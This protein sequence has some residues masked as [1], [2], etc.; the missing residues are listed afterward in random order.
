M[1]E[2]FAL[3]A[4]CLLLAAFCFSAQNSNQSAPRPPE[5][6]QASPSPTSTPTPTP[7]PTPP[8]TLHQWGAVTLFHG[9]PSNRVRAI[10]QGA[11]GAMWFGTDAGLAKY[12][13]R[14]TQAV[15]AEGLSGKRVLALRL[16]E[17]GVLWVGTEDGAARVSGGGEV[18]FIKET[19]GKAVTSVI[20]PERGRAILA[21]EQGVV[22][23]C[24]TNSD[25]RLDVRS[26]PAEPL[27]SAAVDE[28]GALKLT[29]LAM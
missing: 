19:A 15:A 6:A 27:Q 11:D 17:D 8:S 18:Q 3:A 24:R 7:T 26:L 16:D 1:R 14:R 9:L 23:D 4:F 28:P 12:D 10:A 13:G 20:T 25:Q 22:F 21:T 29:S 5:T 2:G